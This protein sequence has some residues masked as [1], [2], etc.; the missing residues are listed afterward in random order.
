MQITYVNYFQCLSGF[1]FYFHLF[2]E[3]VNIVI[4]E[5]V[6]G[7]FIHHIINE[8]SYILSFVILVLAK[9]Q[10]QSTKFIR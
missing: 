5:S 1:I 4:R 2:I 8:L 6:L 7:F 10:V 9:S 3:F